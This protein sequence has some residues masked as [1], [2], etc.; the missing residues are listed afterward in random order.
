MTGEAVIANQRGVNGR[1]LPA[2]AVLGLMYFINAR[3]VTAIYGLEFAPASASF[4]FWSCS[5]SARMASSMAE[6]LFSIC[7]AAAFRKSS[8]SFCTLLRLKVL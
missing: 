7:I 1:A 2:L 3:L 8:S 5:S 4:M 6:R